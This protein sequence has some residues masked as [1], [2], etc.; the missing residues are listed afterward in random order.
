MGEAAEKKEL[1]LTLNLRWLKS[2]ATT[3][4]CVVNGR[5]YES[6]STLVLNGIYQW[7]P[8]FLQSCT[9]S[10]IQIPATN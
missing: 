10:H 4:L 1:C 5:T 9:P 7:F 8:N 2:Q 6:F 3:R